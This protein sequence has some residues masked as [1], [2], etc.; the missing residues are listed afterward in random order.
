MVAAFER[1]GLDVEVIG[2]HSHA[3]RAGCHAPV[4]AWGR[5]QGD[6][7]VL[8]GRVGDPEGTRILRAS[9]RAP[10]ASAVDLGQALAAQLRGRGA[11]D[12]LQDR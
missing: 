12:L 8:D 9:L 11:D 4:G 7:L 6:D 5:L 2:R 1:G 10:L 3:V